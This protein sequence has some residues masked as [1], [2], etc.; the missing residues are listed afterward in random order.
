ME[1]NSLAPL[2]WLVHA[3]ADEAV[4][5]APVNRLVP[6]AKS[7]PSALAGQGHTNGGE[8]SP[9]RSVTPTSVLS[10]LASDADHIGRA[11]EIAAACGSLAELKA[12]LEAFEGCALKK[13]AT[14]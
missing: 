1:T 8:R 11:I 7:S 14:N 3:G 2:A 6:R 13:L 5:E 4:G 9:R 10:P 12:A